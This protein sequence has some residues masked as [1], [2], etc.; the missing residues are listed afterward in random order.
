MNKTPV[1]QKI[2]YALYIAMVMCMIG[3]GA[4][5]I[6]TKQIWCNYFGV[7]GIGHNMSYKLMPVVGS[8]DILMGIIMLFHPNRAIAIWLVG[9]GFATASLRPL[10]G[11]PFAELIERAGNFGAPLSLLLLCGLEKNIKTWFKKIRPE[12]IHFTEKNVPRLEVSLKI[13]VFLLLAGHGWLNFIQKKSIVAQYENMGFSNPMDIA[14]MIGVFEILAA[15]GLLI[16]PVTPLILFLF[17]W[18]MASELFYPH[19][20]IFEWIE[21]G[22]SYGTLLALYF[23]YQAHKSNNFLYTLKERRWNINLF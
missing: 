18:K 13:I 5:G 11:E 10:S 16:K 2:Y 7:F 15:F 22:G 4:F 9:W 1:E 23:Y 21:R 8:I 12:E 17:I 20:E 14:S 3:H 19:W 6:I